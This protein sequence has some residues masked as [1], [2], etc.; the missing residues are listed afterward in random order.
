MIALGLREVEVG[1]STQR[2]GTGR[3]MSNYPYKCTK[4][5]KRDAFVGEPGKYK[6]LECWHGDK[7]R[8]RMR[9]TVKE[10]YGETK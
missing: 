7:F 4:H 5:P 1:I 8:A 6:C 9:T 3:G 10:F 2:V